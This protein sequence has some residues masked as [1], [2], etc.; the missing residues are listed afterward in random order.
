MRGQKRKW[1]GTKVHVIVVSMKKNIYFI[2]HGESEGN[3]LEI[4]QN[5]LTPLTQK[6][7]D[8]AG[9]AKLKLNNLSV[10]KFITSNMKRAKQTGEIIYFD[11]LNGQI[12]KVEESNLFREYIMPSSLH[13]LSVH[14]DEYRK[15]TNLFEENKENLDYKYED[16]ETDREFIQRLED[17]INLLENVQAENIAIVTHGYYLRY[18]LV[19]I[20]LNRPA[21]LELLDRVAD[22][23]RTSNTGITTLS[24]DDARDEKWRLHTFNDYSHLLESSENAGS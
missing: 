13:G 2:R 7:I 21:D 23:F 4:V 5:T 12:E 17:S 19:Y 24:Y 15:V 14:S 1:P 22:R 8:Q 10:D 11:K 6:G 16:E 18:L 9:K 20:L 3:A